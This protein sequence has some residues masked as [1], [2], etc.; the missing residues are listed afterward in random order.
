MARVEQH[1]WY[2]QYLKLK[3]E[4]ADAIL[5][6]RFG[7]FYETFD[8]D[9]KLIAELLDVTLTRKDCAVDRTQ[10]R[11][12]QKIYAPMAG[13]PYHA[14]ERYV[15]DLVG[16][17][18]RVAIAEQISETESSRTDTRPR[19]VFAGGVQTSERPTGGMVHRAIV[20]VITPGTITD[21]SMLNA[22]ANNYL[23][24][25]IVQTDRVGFA[26]A[27]L[28]TAEFAAAE[29]VGERAVAQFQSELARLNVA[30]LLVPDDPALRLAG[31]APN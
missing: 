25:A 6:F 26:Y 1:Q 20:R 13:M 30:E 21:L 28:S 16:R 8:D 17:G 19:S 7:D 27:D 5:L 31:F 18:Y 23:A 22:A 2:R 3:A 12:Q 10:P 11:E 9:A 14:V 4:A 24:A 15:T 29:F